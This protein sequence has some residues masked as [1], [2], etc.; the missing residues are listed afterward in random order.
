M[1]GLCKR[2]QADGSLAGIKAARNCPKINHLLFADDTMFFTITDPQSCSA[3]LDI[4]HSYEAAS[5]QMINVQK[6][7]IS[8]SAKTPQEIRE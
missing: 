3:L 2:A 8:F 7:S 4:L 6:S 5:G 1:S